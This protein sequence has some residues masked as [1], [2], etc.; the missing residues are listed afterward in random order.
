M[1]G[2]MV[3]LSF[4]TNGSNATGSLNTKSVSQ[5]SINRIGVIQ[6]STMAFLLMIVLMM[7]PGCTKTDSTYK[8]ASVPSVSFNGDAYAYLESQ[9]GVFDS[10]LK[11]LARVPGLIDSLR[12]SQVTFFAPANRSF[13][14]A[15]FNANQARL[16]SVPQMP[17]L[18]INTIDVK[19][20]DSTLCKYI[21]RDKIVSSDLFNTLSDGR[22]VATIKY[23]YVMNM[24]ML[25]TNA[26][27]YVAGGP[28]LINFSDRNNSIFTRY[29]VTTKT[30][31][32]DIVTSNAVVNL[33][34]VGHDFGF[35]NTFIRSVNRR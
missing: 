19:L 2:R 22:D 13:E 21:V 10:L 20:L 32:S 17:P 14:I 9:K 23:S 12:S 34:D 4:H 24:K 7:A 35:G 18:D 28:T 6:L 33:L 16:D 26:S 15:L 30:S 11:A 3:R 31:T 1:N 5:S 8:N 25:F 29:W 27:G